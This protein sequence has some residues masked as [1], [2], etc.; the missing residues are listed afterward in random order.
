M[1]EYHAEHD[2]DESP[3]PCMEC[4][5]EIG[6]T[7]TSKIS[8]ICDECYSGDLEIQDDIERHSEFGHYS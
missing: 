4:G 8:G 1:R 7:Q 5:I 2:T 6:S 3:N